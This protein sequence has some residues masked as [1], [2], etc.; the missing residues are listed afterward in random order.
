MYRNVSS[1]YGALRDQYVQMINSALR[2]QNAA[3][4]KAMMPKITAANEQLVAL[5]GRIQEIYDEGQ[6]VLSA[7]PTNDLQEA[8]DKYKEQLERVCAQM[9]TS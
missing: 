4:R 7:Q 5:V 8:L 6:S 1:E 9:K 3:K 2:Q